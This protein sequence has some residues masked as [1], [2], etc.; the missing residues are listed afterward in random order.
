MRALVAG[1]VIM[2]FGCGDQ[3]RA[4]G[5]APRRDGGT[6]AALIAPPGVVPDASVEL[7]RHMRDHLA[8]VARA[9]EAVVRGQL[10]EARVQA[11]WLA[12]QPAHVELDGSAAELATLRA[13]AEALVAAP[14]LTAAAT[15]MARLGGACAACHEARGT[16]VAFTWEPPPDEDPSLARQMLRHQWAAARLWQGVVGPSATL[17]REGATM[18]SGLRLDVGPLASG[19]DADAVKRAVARL[20][21]LASQ[22]ARA[23]DTPGRTALYGELLDACVGCHTRVRPAPRPMP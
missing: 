18:L 11:R 16:M 4:S 9:Q 21:T 3:T 23:T 22:A 19:A 12:A 1:L 2:M 15:A 5:A 20:R 10:E 8:V 17:W 7:A 13:A 14:D 6:A